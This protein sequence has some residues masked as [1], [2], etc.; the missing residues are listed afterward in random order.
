MYIIEMDVL[1]SDEIKTLPDV[2]I[3]EMTPPLKTKKTYEGEETLKC[4]FRS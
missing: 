3:D 4:Q 2:E 1:H